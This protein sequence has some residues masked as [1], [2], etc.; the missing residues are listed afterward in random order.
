MK[1]KYMK[2]FYKS[3][4][5]IQKIIFL[6]YLILQKFGLLFFVFSKINFYTF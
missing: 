5:Q 4:S 3:F 2:N 6:K 1:K